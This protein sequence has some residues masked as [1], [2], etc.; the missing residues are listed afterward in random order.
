M[1]TQQQPN[2][3]CRFP[4]YADKNRRLASFWNW[5]TTAIQTPEQLA[6]AG[7]FYTGSSDL[8]QCFYCGIGLCAWDSDDDPWEEHARSAPGCLYIIDETVSTKEDN[9]NTSQSITD[10]VTVTGNT[11]PL[12]TEAAQSVLEEGY[13][14]RVVKMAVDKILH[15]KGWSELTHSALV[16][17]IIA[18]Q[19]SGEIDKDKCM[20]PKTLAE[21]LRKKL[22]NQVPD[23]IP[24][25][26]KYVEEKKRLLY[27]CVCKLLPCSFIMVSC[28]HMAC[29]QCSQFHSA[30]CPV[31][32]K[33]ITRYYSIVF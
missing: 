1:T 15:S 14:P 30:T 32:Y 31:C 18:M 3:P 2:S 17:Q 8:V 21:G 29:S 9:Q 12:Q 24:A 16:A 22:K 33:D 28:G 25:L 6:S 4:E 5:P 13:L 20:K 26:K 23:D 27:C 11:N 7:F 10:T 19:E